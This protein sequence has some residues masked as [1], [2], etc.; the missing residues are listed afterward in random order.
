[1]FLI[2]YDIA[3]NSNE[4]TLNPDVNNTPVFTEPYWGGYF[5]SYPFTRVF[6]VSFIR[7]NLNRRK[8]LF[9]Q[10]YLCLYVV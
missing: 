3:L 7:Y 5:G 1:M 8:H 6:Q 9:L 2:I 4:F 10:K